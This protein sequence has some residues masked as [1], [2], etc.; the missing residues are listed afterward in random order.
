MSEK[1]KD[2]EKSVLKAFDMHHNQSNETSEAEALQLLSQLPNPAA[3]RD[4]DEHH[5]TLLHHAC[6]NGWYEVTKVL[7]EKY[8]CDPNC[9]NASG[10]IPLRLACWSGNLDLVK[11]LVNDKRNDPNHKNNDGF[12]SMHNASMGGHLQTVKY[13]VEIQRCDPNCRSNDGFTP[14]HSACK[15]RHLNVAK[16]LVDENIVIQTVVTRT[17]G[18]HCI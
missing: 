8:N 14:L 7:I 13:L 15:N 3:V 1:G 2:L 4:E 10:S 12:T 6:C 18:L 17:A 5:F 16:Y 11:Y 9:K